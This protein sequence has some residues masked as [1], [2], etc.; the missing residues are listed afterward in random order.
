[1]K[2]FV[3]FI[4]TEIVQEIYFRISFGKIRKKYNFLKIQTFVGKYFSAEI[5]FGSTLK[6]WGIGQ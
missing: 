5:S 2:R 4:L 3:F 1:M 6:W